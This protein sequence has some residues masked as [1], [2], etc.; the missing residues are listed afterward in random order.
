MKGIVSI[1]LGVIFLTSGCLNAQEQNRR[2]D[3][4]SK[5]ERMNE[6]N[7]QAKEDLGL[8]DEQSKEWNSIQ[9]DFM[10]EKDAIRNNEGLTQDQRREKQQELIKNKDKAIK[11]ILT[12][13]QYLSYQEIIKEKRKQFGNGQGKGKNG[14]MGNYDRGRQMLGQAK[15][16][17]DLSKE[18][19]E[20]WD[21]I[22]KSYGDKMRAIKNDDS[23]DDT[24]RRAEVNT[25][26]VALEKELMAI[27]DSE[28]QEAFQ[29]L[30]KEN[31]ERRKQQRSGSGNR[32]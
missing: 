5:K 19:S 29:K 7:I 9:K 22:A 18:Q 26:K 3:Q 14:S 1:L 25:N 2:Q 11:T 21:A 12:E 6:M 13:E 10:Q 31:K 4:Q 28:Q 23:L 24:Q 30:I 17:L 32:G 15:L 8:S 27:L 16:D 20:Q